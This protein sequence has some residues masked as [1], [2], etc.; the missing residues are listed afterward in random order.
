MAA[1]SLPPSE[2]A[3]G[4]S[5]LRCSLVVGQGSLAA[6]G[7]FSTPQTKPSRHRDRFCGYTR[8]YIDI[9]A[10]GTARNCTYQNKPLLKSS[11]LGVLT[12]S[13]SELLVPA[14]DTPEGRVRMKHNHYTY[15]ELIYNVNKEERGE[16]VAA[17]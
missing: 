12:E 7:P 16:G 2:R 10:R 6:V 13:D 9:N 5:C 11:T 4:V 14:F 1:V 8:V 15:E 3:F 17:G